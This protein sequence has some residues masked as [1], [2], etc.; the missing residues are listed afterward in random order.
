MELFHKIA[1]AI[2]S[3]RALIIGIHRKRDFAL[4]YK[5]IVDAFKKFMRHILVAFIVDQQLRIATRFYAGE[6]IAVIQFAE[7]QIFKFSFELDV[8]ISV[9][10]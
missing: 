7:V 9:Y 10:A 1:Q 4:Q 8:G 3:Y 2:L 6:C 5:R